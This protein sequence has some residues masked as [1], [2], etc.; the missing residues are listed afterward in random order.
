MIVSTEVPGLCSPIFFHPGKGHFQIHFFFHADLP[1]PCGNN[2][3]RIKTD[4]QLLPKGGFL[5][6]HEIKKNLV[7]VH[8]LND[9][10]AS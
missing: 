7:T 3:F 4:F 8:K 5:V 10:S 2:S 1:P 9:I 6:G